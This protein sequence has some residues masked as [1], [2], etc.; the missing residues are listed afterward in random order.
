MLPYL[1]L[2]DAVLKFD[3]E[4]V[5]KYSEQIGISRSDLSKISIEA[6]K[7]ANYFE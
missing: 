1:R 7:W 3:W 6:H 4:K 5:D 2:S